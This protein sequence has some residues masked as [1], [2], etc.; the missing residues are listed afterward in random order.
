MNRRFNDKQAISRGGLLS[1][2]YESAMSALGQKQ[3]L[4]RRLLMS[5]LPPKADIRRREYDVRFVPQADK[6]RRSKTSQETVNP[7]NGVERKC[8]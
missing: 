2:G 5:A 4:D 7:R 6:V 1:S 8:H 3:T